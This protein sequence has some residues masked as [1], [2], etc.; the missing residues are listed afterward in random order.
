MSDQI[1]RT[2]TILAG[3]LLLGVIAFQVAL[4]AGV[5]WGRAAY[6]GGSAEL[7]P[8]YR[9]ASMVAVVVWTV[10][11]LTVL[12]LGG[13]GLWTPIPDRY[14][15]MAGWGIVGVLAISVVMNAITPSRIER[16]IWLPTTVLL[17]TCVGAIVRYRTPS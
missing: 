1:L 3:A 16:A 2:V 15:S 14:L 4:A 9:I 7:A 10:V 13:F 5:P 11:G 12:R 8:A 17:L 6:G